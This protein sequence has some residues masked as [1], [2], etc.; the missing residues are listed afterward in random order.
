MGNLGRAGYGATLDGMVHFLLELPP[1][2]LLNIISFSGPIHTTHAMSEQ[3]QIRPRMAYPKLLQK[4]VL[5][6]RITHC[7]TSP[8]KNFLAVLVR[9]QVILGLCTLMAPM[10]AG[11]L[12]QNLIKAR[13]LTILQRSTRNRHVWSSGYRHSSH[14]T[15]I[16]IS[17]MGGTNLIFPP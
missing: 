17:S 12:G 14:R 16:P 13:I 8:G 4:T 1:I 15:S 10:S 9:V 3:H 7:P 5:W 11:Q 2:W 6:L